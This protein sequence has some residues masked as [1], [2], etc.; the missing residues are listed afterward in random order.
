MHTTHLTLQAIPRGGAAVHIRTLIHHYSVSLTS[1]TGICA[2][3]SL[4]PD[5]CSLKVLEPFR[6]GFR[7]QGLQSQRDPRSAIHQGD[8]S[9]SDLGSDPKAAKPNMSG[10]ARTLLPFLGWLL[11]SQNADGDAIW[12][13]CCVDSKIQSYT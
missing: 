7:S 10:T 1:T 6:F 8:G 2:A 5:Q 12:L 3:G 13:V 11:H 4:T 9:P